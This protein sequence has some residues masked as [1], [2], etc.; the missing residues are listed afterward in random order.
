MN[1]KEIAKFIAGV[2]GNQVMT[3]GA[4]LI[5]GVQFTMFGFSYTTRLNTIAVIFWAIVLVLTVYYAW[6]RK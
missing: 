6:F 5:S 1:W 2:A 3:H 4:F